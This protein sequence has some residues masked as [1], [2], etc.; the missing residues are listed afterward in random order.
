MNNKEYIYK[1][2]MFDGKTKTDAYLYI[3]TPI[4]IENHEWEIFNEN[5]IIIKSI[6]S[7]AFPYIYPNMNLTYKKYES[8]K[9]EKYWWLK[10]IKIIENFRYL[11][12]NNNIYKYKISLIMPYN[13]DRMCEFDGSLKEIIEYYFNFAD[14]RHCIQLVPS[15]HSVVEI[16][17]S[18]N[19][20]IDKKTIIAI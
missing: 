12:N 6:W 7:G 16:Y 4:L 5:H 2:K 11:N 18:N 20:I 1:F 9:D 14:A 19:L 15:I 8:M 13:N 17:N 3:I 10:K